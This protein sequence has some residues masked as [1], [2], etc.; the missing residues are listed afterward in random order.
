M[1]VNEALLQSLLEGIEQSLPPH[2]SDRQVDRWCSCIYTLTRLSVPAL[3]TT[4]MSFALLI[5]SAR[6]DFTLSSL[7][8]YRQEKMGTRVCRLCE[9]VPSHRLNVAHSY[10]VQVPGSPQ[11]EVKVDN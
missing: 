3:L 8:R 5:T 7:Y 6:M 2:D 1:A 4:A 9:L 11:D 10:Y